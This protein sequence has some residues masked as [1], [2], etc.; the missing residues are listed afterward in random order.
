MAGG[1]VL[2]G[3]VGYRWFGDA[4]FGLVASDQMAQLDWP[5]GVDVQDLGYGALHV[6]LDLQ[7]AHPPYDRVILIG[8]T[9]RGRERAR[10]YRFDCDGTAADG[11]E[12]QDRMYEAGGGVIELDH[13]VV[14]GRHFSALSDDVVAIELEPHPGTTGDGLSPE[15]QALLPQAIELVRREILASAP[16]PAV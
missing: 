7:A 5:D 8:A 11:K 9:E 2:I 4:S 1:R 12:V 6:A 13:L 10:L 16:V 14:I 3:G 15:V